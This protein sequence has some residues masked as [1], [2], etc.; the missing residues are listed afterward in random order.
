M[1]NDVIL[2]NILLVKCFNQ[3]KSAMSES[4]ADAVSLLNNYCWF[5]DGHTSE[6]EKC[7]DENVLL[8]WFG[9]SIKGRKNVAEFLKTHKVVSRH[10]FNKIIPVNQISY[11]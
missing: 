4:F 11:M 1:I 10:I 9:K 6:F 3:W 5:A 2:I 7:L 8:D